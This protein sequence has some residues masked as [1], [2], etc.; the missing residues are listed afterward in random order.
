MEPRVFEYR[1][2]VSAAP[3]KSTE[4]L[5]RTTKL[6]YAMAALLSLLA[7]ASLA[8]LVSVKPLQMQF[9]AGLIIL[10]G[11]AV[12]LFRKANA[13]RRGLVRTDGSSVTEHGP[14]PLSLT[15]THLHF[16]ESFDSAEDD[17]PL[18]GTQV[19]LH[20]AARQEILVVSHPG[21]TPRHFYANALQDGVEAILAEIEARQ[22][23][24]AP[25][26]DIAPEPEQQA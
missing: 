11:G 21:K 26:P 7:V 12:V 19:A 22:A 10:I 16:P 3:A 5:Q 6:S 17:W 9:I 2:W 20:T 15:D 4:Q 14:Y 1:P 25:A 23:S 13:N 18:A 8:V 24:A